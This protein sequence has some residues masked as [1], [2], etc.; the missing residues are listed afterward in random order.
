[1]STA[2]DFIRER[3]GGTVRVSTMSN[4]ETSQVLLLKSFGL[5]PQAHELPEATRS[6]AEAC[7][8]ALLWRDMAYGTEFMS[9]QKADDYARAFL[10]ECAGED[11]RFFINGRWD[12]YHGSSGFSYSPLTSATFSATLL[13]VCPGVATCFLVEDED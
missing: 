9:K 8:S 2:L 3:D 10:D 1:M 5:Q 12:L 4:H 13:V 6:I 11:A 7:I